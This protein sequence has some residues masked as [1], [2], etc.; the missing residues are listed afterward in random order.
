MKLVREIVVAQDTVT[1]DTT[2]TV[3]AAARLMS[4][5]HIGA[6]PVLDGDRVVG[7]FSERDALTRVIGG[8]L[9]PATTTI[10]QVMS[11]P[12]IVADIGDTYEACLNRMTDEH[13][14]HLIVLD[15]ERMAG[16][17]SMRDLMEIDLVEKVQTI[18]LLHEYI[19]YAP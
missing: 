1:V 17:V 12:L 15:G 4:E 3:T 19:H 6:V 9:D 10:S 5:R 13:V 8:G 2:T 14:R 18:A 11:S 16:V 7:I